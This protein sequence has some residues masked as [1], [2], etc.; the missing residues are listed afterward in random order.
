MHILE[1]LFGK[2]PF[3]PLIEHAKKVNECVDLIMPITEA[4]LQEEWDKVQQLQ[5]VISEREHEADRIKIQLRHY[6][7]KGQYYAVPRGDL[8]RVTQNQDNIADAIE[9]YG[10]LLTLRKT[11][12]PDGLKAE[13]RLFVQKV[14]QTCQKAL[15]ATKELDAL[16]ETS[17]SGPEADKVHAIVEEVAKLEYEVD[18]A[19]HALVRKLLMLEDTISALNIMFCMNIIHTLSHLCNY[20][21]NSGDNLYHMIISKK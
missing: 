19:S 4:W 5:K 11:I 13:L 18:H 1:K 14:I 15:Y 2:S 9:D 21:E 16:L 8:F 20:A 3:G 10:I 6:L 17:F 12:F 7:P